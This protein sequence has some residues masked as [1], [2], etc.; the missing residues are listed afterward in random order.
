MDQLYIRIICMVI[1]FLIS[2]I[3]FLLPLFIKKILIKRKKIFDTITSILNCLSSGIFFGI[4]T[5]DL[6]PAAIE[7]FKQ[8]AEMR[9]IEIK[10]PIAELCTGL[11]F[12]LIYMIEEFQEYF[13][14]YIYFFFA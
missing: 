7:E 6:W 1:L 12:F 13:S 5:L 3:F 11:G 10:F 4:I 9:K 8:E 14:N 2:G